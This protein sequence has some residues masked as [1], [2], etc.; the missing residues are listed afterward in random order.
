M[1]DRP[2]TF[3]QFLDLTGSKDDLEL[4]KGVLIEKMAAQ[5]PHEQRVVWLLGILSFYVSKRRLGTVLGSRTPVQIDAFGGRLPDV[6][7]VSAE[8][9]QIVQ[10]KAILGAPDLVIEIVSPNDRP[11]DLLALETDYR[12]IGVR[13]IVFVD[14]PEHKLLVL[15]QRENDYAVDTL[16]AGIFH[17]ETVPG[18]HF[19]VEAIF[20]D[21]LPDRY[22]ALTALLAEENG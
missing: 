10:K 21:P 2:I 8:R 16:L 3:D 22:D 20:S 1:A 11:S 17:S 12:S 15:R 13:E 9:E 5:L 19:D 18:F 4:V 6:L 7:F 14:V